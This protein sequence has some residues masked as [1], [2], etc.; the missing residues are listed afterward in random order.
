MNICIYVYFVEN[1][2]KIKIFSLILDLGKTKVFVSE[3]E[4]HY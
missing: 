2:I 4:K 3:S 1:N